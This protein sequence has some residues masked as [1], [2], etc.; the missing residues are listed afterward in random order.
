VIKANNEF[1]IKS[2]L[3]NH[4]IR[5]LIEVQKEMNI[6]VSDQKGIW[7]EKLPE[8]EFELSYFMEGEIKDVEE[9]KLLLRLF[10]EILDEL[11]QMK[12]I[13]YMKLRVN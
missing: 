1:K 10:K 3:Q 12:S 11:Y 7:E 4:K 8:K 6:E 13:D 5:N 2:L 9:L